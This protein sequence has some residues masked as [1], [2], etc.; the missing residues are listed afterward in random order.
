MRRAARDGEGSQARQAGSVRRDT[1]WMDVFLQNLRET[2]ARRGKP[3]V[4]LAAEL[5]GES[6]SLIYRIR[7]TERGKKLK[8]G[9]DQIV[10]KSKP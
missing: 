6:R 2:A 4:K 1:A 7:R 5:T 10:R 9:W 3:D 8:E